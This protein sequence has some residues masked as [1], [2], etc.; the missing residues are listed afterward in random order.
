MREAS[1]LRETAETKIN[2]TLQL[3][4]EGESHVS[5]GCG[6]LDH[7]LTL[8]ASH[9]RFNLTLTCVGDT[10]VDDHHTVEDIGIALGQAFSIALGEKRGICRYGSMIL[11]MD[12]ALI[13]SA[14]DLSGRGILCDALEI[15][16]EKVGSFDTELVKEFWL[17][18]VRNAECALH[19]RQLAGE[20][21]HHIIE[22]AF[23]SVARSLRQA[24]AMDAA[25][26]DEIPSTKGV[27]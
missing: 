6:F 13:L 27:L 21:S 20:N 25:F 7:M 8:F 19:I 1:I 3:D 14:V 23:K 16:T 10:Q 15:P 22:G 11:P 26:A 17:A 24:V 9:G 2:L 4:G 5:S 12:E 18:F